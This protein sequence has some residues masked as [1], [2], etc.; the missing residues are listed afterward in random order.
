MEKKDVESR[1]GT[2][3]VLHEA[4]F[5]YSRAPYVGDV[6]GTQRWVWPHWTSLH[7]SR[8][9]MWSIVTGRSLVLL[10]GRRGWQNWG[11][12]LRC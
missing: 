6:V 7:W 10:D 11:G 1:E 5:K 9:G 8:R 12:C 3:G 4:L 2:R